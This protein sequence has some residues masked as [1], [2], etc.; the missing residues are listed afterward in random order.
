MRGT[1]ALTATLLATSLLA[2][3][4]T[5]SIISSY[6]TRRLGLAAI[7]QAVV[8][9]WWV[10]VALAY[11]ATIGWMLA[12]I[13]VFV[14]GVVRHLRRTSTRRTDKSVSVVPDTLTQ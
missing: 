9:G 11:A 6:P 3:H 13:T 8:A 7:D 4:V 1:I 12:T 5:N 10:T 14:V 2:W